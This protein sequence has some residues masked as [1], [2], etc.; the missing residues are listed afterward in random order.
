LLCL[1]VFQICFGQPE[2]DSISEKDLQSEATVIA[3][4]QKNYNN[5]QNNDNEFAYF[6]TEV[7]HDAGWRWYDI[8][9]D[10]PQERCRNVPKYEV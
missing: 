6:E 10:I 1:P 5:H 8:N 3:E 4:P 9:K 2:V 7:G